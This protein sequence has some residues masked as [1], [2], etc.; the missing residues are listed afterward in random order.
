MLERYRLINYISEFWPA[1][2]NATTPAAGGQLE[3]T[4]VIRLFTGE[5][6]NWLKMYDPD[7]PWDPRGHNDNF[8]SPLYY[9]ARL[10]LANVVELL[11]DKGAD[12]NAQGGYYDTALQAA[13]H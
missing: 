8:R 2:L 10:G 7:T 1:H 5:I 3:R 4:L 11:L 13:S 9:S 12:V 6:T